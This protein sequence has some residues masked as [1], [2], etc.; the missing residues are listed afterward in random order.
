[1][2]NVVDSPDEARKATRYQIKMRVDFIKIMGTQSHL[3]PGLGIRSTNELT[4]ETMQSIC[5]VAHWARRHVGMH[6]SGGSGV[7]DAIHA[8]VNSYEHGR[9]LSDEQ[10]EMM[11]ERGMFLVPTLSPE[12]RA[13]EHGQEATGFTDESWKWLLRANDVMYDTVARAHKAGVKVAIGSDAAMP[14][15]RH[16]ESAYEMELFVR[17]GLSP[18]DAIVAATKIGAEVVDMADELGTVEEGKLA[19]LVVVDGDPL[20]DITI[21][22]DLSRIK[23]VIK[24]GQ[25]VVS[26]A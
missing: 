26:R 15:V 16:G 8:G 17:A 18:M 4:F 6:C 24:A 9:F 10:L 19:D 11:A 3:V 12:G 20:A 21:L 22:Q 14:L 7:T 13:M 23:K 1:M 5:Q 2:S 25:V